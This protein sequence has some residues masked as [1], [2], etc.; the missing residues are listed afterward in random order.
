MT[1][2]TTFRTLALWTLGTTLAL[3]HCDGLDGPV[4]LDARRAL[5]KNEVNHVLLWVKASDEAAVREA[6]TR[7]QTVRRLGG[8][9]Q[10]LADQFFFETVVR[11]H[12]A[13]EGEPFTGL[14]PAGRDLG[15]A[16]PAGDQALETGELKPVW[17]LIRE[18]AHEG[19]HA[20]FEAVRQA[21]ALKAKDPASGRR[22]VAAYVDYIHYVVGLHDLTQGAHGPKEGS[23]PRHACG[24]GTAT[25]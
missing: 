3:A 8:E 25:E 12:R 24:S 14:K 2:S 10:K 15:P 4:V 5:D 13:S 11:L 9:A 1:L 23:A 22:F 20:R 7:A 18:K 16:I 21:Q 6:F 17:D 19:L